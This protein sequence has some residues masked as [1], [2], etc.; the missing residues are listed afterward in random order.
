VVAPEAWIFH[1]GLTFS[2]RAND[3]KK[4]KDLYGIWYVATQ[5]G[6]FSDETISKLPALIQKWPPKW[7]K[8]FQGNLTKWI[9]EASPR[10]WRQLEAQD[11]FGK[12]SKLQFELLIQNITSPRKPSL[13]STD[14][15]DFSNILI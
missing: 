2:K 13:R 9:E 6:S 10:D 11:P 8:T 1:K 3:F 14:T 5:L 7:I 15:L 12:L 4:Y